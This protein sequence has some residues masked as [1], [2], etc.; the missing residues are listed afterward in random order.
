MNRLTRYL[1]RLFAVDALAMFGIAMPILFLV[2]CLTIINANAVRGQGLGL[3]L[4]QVLLAMPA[5]AT[6]VL[7]VCLGLG[8]GRALRGLQASRELQIIHASRRLGAL[9]QAIGLY[10]LAG[11]IAVLLLAHLLAPVSVQQAN[12]L[13]AQAAADLVSRT[14]VPDRFAQ[15]G[16]GVTVKIGGRL[17]DGEV[18]SFFADDLRDPDSRRTYIAESAVIAA[19]ELGYVL[20][21]RNGAVQYRTASGQFS[22]ISF[23]S[24]ALALDQLTGALD[25]TARESVS[26][27][28]LVAAGDWS[29]AVVKD[30]VSRTAEGLR[31][32]GLCLFAGCISAFPSGRR[33]PHWLPIEVVVLGAAIAERGITSYLPATGP[34]V[35]LS[36]SMLLILVA[37]VVF[38][39]RLR[40]FAPLPTA[41]PAP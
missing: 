14:L 19:D 16:D 28:R 11:T 41:R 5:P 22:E 36:G 31:V 35:P 24:Y 29:P 1:L 23:S 2:Q 38:V 4:V 33:R 40:L 18:A 17:A 26:S 15:V 13:R 39:L 3:L 10:T 32:M 6:V 12:L 25:V 9:L 34:L 8:L 37:L 27:L 20:Q 21:L 7:A 30:L